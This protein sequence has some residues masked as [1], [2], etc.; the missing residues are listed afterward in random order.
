M[1]VV[2]PSAAAG[3]SA[4]HL[5][6]TFTAAVYLAGSTVCHQRAERSFHPGGIR[7]P[8]CARCF[9]LYVGATL[10]ALVALA[11]WT[12][13]GTRG[14]RVSTTVVRLVVIAAAVP[15]AIVWAVE[16][17]GLMHPSA[18]VRAVLASPLGGAAAWAIVA[19]VAGEIE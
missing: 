18:A 17:L 7:M 1:L 4:I 16:W 15:T 10:G 12:V 6:V 2:V 9:G 19:M 11:P 8:V 5:P 14:R 13:S 3:K